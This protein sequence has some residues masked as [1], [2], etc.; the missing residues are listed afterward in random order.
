MKGRCG[1]SAVRLAAM[2]HKAS[3]AAERLRAKRTLPG[4]ACEASARFLGSVR[5]LVLSVSPKARLE[6]IAARLLPENDA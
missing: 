2:L 4:L 3:R 6:R 1:E 5:Q